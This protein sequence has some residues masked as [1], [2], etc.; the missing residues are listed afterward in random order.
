MRSITNASQGP[1]ET[2]RTIYCQGPPD[3]HISTECAEVSRT[4]QQESAA[5][6]NGGNDLLR[7]LLYDARSRGG[8]GAVDAT[9]R[10]T[11]QVFLLAHSSDP[12]YSR[13]RQ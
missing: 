3:S 5:A 6:G 13:P 2:V 8:G 9:A 1:H 11:S 7:E 10:Q 4:G 12:C